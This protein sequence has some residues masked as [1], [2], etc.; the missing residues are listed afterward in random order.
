M[1]QKPPE[2]EE[3]G[4]G[5][6]EL[7]EEE[8]SEERFPLSTRF[9][10][11]ES[12]DSEGPDLS[13]PV[14]KKR[15]LLDPV[16]PEETQA[17]EEEVGERFTRR[18]N[19]V[20]ALEKLN[21]LLSRESWIQLVR[22]KL[23]A[24]II[25]PRDENLVSQLTQAF[26]NSGFPRD[27]RP[28]I[29]NTKNS[30]LALSYPFFP[31]KLAQQRTLDEFVDY[32]REIYQ[33]REIG[34]RDPDVNRGFFAEINFETRKKILSQL[35]ARSQSYR[36]RTSTSR[37]NP[38]KRFMSLKQS[39]VRPVIQKARNKDG[40]NGDSGAASTT[41]TSGNVIHLKPFLRNPASVN[42][43]GSDNSGVAVL[44]G[45]FEKVTNPE[46]ERL[47]AE[48][49][50]ALQALANY[51]P[52]YP[53]YHYTN[54]IRPDVS[55]F[56]GARGGHYGDD[57]HDFCQKVIPFSWATGSSVPTSPSSPLHHSPHFVSEDLRL[58]PAESLAIYRNDFW[59]ARSLGVL[60][61]Q[62]ENFWTQ[63]AFEVRDLGWTC[64]RGKLP[65]LGG[66]R[67]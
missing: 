29:T 55:S 47:Q 44:Q 37:D 12:S 7:P 26:N 8:S 53:V 41:T 13:R 60:H 4:G 52:R 9:E 14:P 61:D 21:L 20:N 64:R 48:R 15:S 5:E 67:G 6:E 51:D 58:W 16:L 63:L 42:D 24:R 45:P 40:G 32:V 36:K 39:Q 54:I 25:Y 18:T 19:I 10:S 34:I 62:Y 43:S 46:Y 30:L 56:L 3:E 33:V 49:T 22:F 27:L 11:E 50:K 35:S 57:P 28:L 59:V 31:Q 23:L 2:E 17:I 1:V 65:R 66:R 38:A